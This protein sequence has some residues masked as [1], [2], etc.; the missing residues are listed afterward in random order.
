MGEKRRAGPAA[1]AAALIGVGLA[2]YRPARVPELRVGPLGAPAPSAPAFAS[3][4]NW[5]PEP[6]RETPIE[7]SDGGAG[8]ENNEEESDALHDAPSD[9]SYWAGSGFPSATG[10]PTAGSSRIDRI[11]RTAPSSAETDLMRPSAASRVTAAGPKINAPW[12]PFPRGAAPPLKSEARR[13][14]LSSGPAGP[15]SVSRPEE[16]RAVDP[17]RVAPRPNASAWFRRPNGSFPLFRPPRR[18]AADGQRRPA[19][20]RRKTKPLLLSKLLGRGALRPPPAA[21]VPPDLSSLMTRRP[22]SLPNGTPT[23]TRP[24]DLD[25]IEAQDPRRASARR[26]RKRGAH[27]DAGLLWHDGPARGVIED[28]RWLWLW[29]DQSRVWAARTPEEAPLL[30]HQGLWWSKQRGVW[31]ALHDGELWSWRRFADWDA[32]GL[33]RLTDGVELVYSADFSR[34]AVITP[35]AGAVLYDAVTGAEIGQWLESELPRRRPRAPSDLRL[36]RGI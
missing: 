10:A 34:V 21:I 17:R 27:W 16:R 35:G 6:E 23:P 36:P 7:E 11:M 24:Y 30:R 32:E 5:S 9:R 25:R 33:I 28:A 20:S 15:E 1:I 2:L 26:D 3:A 29:K 8:E 18:V 14:L 13:A 22:A 4:I 19:A 12:S 31:F